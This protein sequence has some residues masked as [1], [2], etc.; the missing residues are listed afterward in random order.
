MQGSYDSQLN[1]TYSDALAAKSPT[2]LL[3]TRWPQVRLLHCPSCTHHL[4]P[5]SWHPVHSAPPSASTSNPYFPVPNG[6]ACAVEPYDCWTTPECVPRSTASDQPAPRAYRCLDTGCVRR[7][8]P[9]RPVGWPK[10]WFANGVACAS[11][12][13]LVRCRSRTGSRRIARYWCFVGCFGSG[14]YYCC[15]I[16]VLC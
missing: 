12:W 9:A 7:L 14:W 8:A 1:Y 16:L 6:S 2:H 15:W 4:R 11:R 3:P 13:C 10:K 5:D